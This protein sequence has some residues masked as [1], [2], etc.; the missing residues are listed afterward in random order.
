MIDVSSGEEALALLDEI[1]IVPDRFL[2]DQELGAGL[3]GLSLVG[4]LRARHGAIAA[5]LL[6]ASRA[7]ALDAACAASDVTV[8]RK[9]V[10]AAVLAAFLLR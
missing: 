6:T 4:Q 1:G 8:L 5:R 7:P 9:P 2:I 10:D 3:D